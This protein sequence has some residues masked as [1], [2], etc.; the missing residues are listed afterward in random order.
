MYSLSTSFCTVPESFARGAA[1]VGD[2]DDEGEEN[3]GVALIVMERLTWSRG[4][5]GGAAHVVGGRD[6]DA[7]PADLALGADG[8]VVTH[9]RQEIEGDRELICPRRR[10]VPLIGCLGVPTG[11]LAHRPKARATRSG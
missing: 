11:A 9:L 1:P 10:M 7:D 4:I 2:R 8:Q 3:H 6:R 5:P